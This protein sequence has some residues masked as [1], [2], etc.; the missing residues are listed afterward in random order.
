MTRPPVA[1]P[2]SRRWAIGYPDGVTE[3]ADDSA[4][5]NDLEQ[6]RAGD[7]DAIDRLLGLLEEQLPSQASRQLGQSLRGKTRPSDLAQSAYVAILQ[8]MGNFRGATEGEFRAWAA[9][10]LE[11]AARQEHRRLNASKRKAPSRTSQLN[12]LAQTL[13]RP[14][15][16]A[17][18]E[19]VSL[20]QVDLVSRAIESLT[21][22]QR[23]AIE[24]CVLGQRSAADVAD[25]LGRSPSAV[26]MLVS[27]ARAALLLAIERLERR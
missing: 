2:R 20:E 1:S 24:E 22:D 4:F 17:A 14:Q 3:A 27:R 16:S 25:E 13:L 12:R 11:N 5:Q 6:A 23:F 15:P 9:K 8:Q 7:R 18:S 19:V 26:H 21:P 10:I